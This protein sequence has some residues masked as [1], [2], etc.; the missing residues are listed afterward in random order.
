MAMS[1]EVVTPEKKVVFE[2]EVHSCVIP[3]EMGQMEVL[4][5]H[6]N[7]MTNLVPGTFAYQVKEGDS[8][9]W[10]ALSGGYAQVLHGKVTVLAET[11]ELAAEIDTAKIDLKKKEL[12]AKLKEIETGTVEYQDTLRELDYLAHATAV[13]K[14]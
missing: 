5:G 3:G 9:I 11:M 12:K 7:M 13:Q 14:K 4:D 1:L 2:S 8:Y 10:A 6:I